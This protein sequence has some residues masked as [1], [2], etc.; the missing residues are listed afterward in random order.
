[1]FVE[2]SSLYRDAIGARFGALIDFL[3]RRSN[4]WFHAERGIAEKV[5]SANNQS[6]NGMGNNVSHRP[7]PF[8]GLCMSWPQG[9]QL[10]LC[11]SF[12]RHIR[13]M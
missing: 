11:I 3:R 1:M 10:G 13:A 6:I 2:L 4:D 7:L 9:S 8:D 12:N 5:N